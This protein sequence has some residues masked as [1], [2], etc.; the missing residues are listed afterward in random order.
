MI[1]NFVNPALQ[2]IAGL[3]GNG[4][5]INGLGASAQAIQQAEQARMQGLGQEYTG[6]ASAALGPAQAAEAARV[7]ELLQQPM[8]SPNQPRQPTGG[9]QP[10]GAQQ[11]PAQGGHAAQGQQAQPQQAQTAEQLQVAQQQPAQVGAQGSLNP[12]QAGGSALS[13][14]FSAPAQGTAPI[15]SPVQTAMEGINAANAQY[16]MMNPS[17]LD[18][19]GQ[20]WSNFTNS[21][22]GNDIYGNP[23]TGKELGDYQS[24]MGLAS[25]LSKLGGAVAG[26]DTT[27]GRFAGGLNSMQQGAIMGANA[28]SGEGRMGNMGKGIAGVGAAQSGA[29]TAQ[30]APSV[31]KAGATSQATSSAPTSSRGRSGVG[32]SGSAVSGFTAP[33]MPELGSGLSPSISGQM[34]RMLI[35]RLGR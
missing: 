5:A 18:N 16:E 32:K 31:S 23:L 30:A 27:I 33:S 9:Q 34:S 29:A 19:P 1:G 10:A 4:A 28:R 22:A 13:G 7:Q 12:G 26:P 2:L 20:W 24:N 14:G 15:S 8:A 11:Q 17:L 25:L 35:E 3:A 6:G 21:L